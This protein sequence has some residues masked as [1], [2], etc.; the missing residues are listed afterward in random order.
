VFQYACMLIATPK[1]LLFANKQ[2]E[3]YSFNETTKN[4]KLLR[5][6]FN[7]NMES[8][9]ANST[10]L[11]FFEKGS[12]II[13]RIPLS[14][15]E[16]YFEQKTK[17]ANSQNVK[18][19]V[20]HGHTFQAHPIISNHTTMSKT[21]MPKEKKQANT[22]EIEQKGNLDLQR[23]DIFRYDTEIEVFLNLEKD[24]LNGNPN[25]TPIKLITNDNKFVI[26]D[27]QGELYSVDLELKE[28]ELQTKAARNFQCLFMLRNCHLSNT[29]LIGEGDLLLLDPIR[30]SLNKL[31]IVAGSEIIVLH[32]TKFLY[33]I[34][35]IFSA[36]GRIYFIDSSG[37]LYYFNEMDKKLTQIGNNG[38]CKYIIDF[39]VQKNY[40]LT[41]ENTNILY[42]TN[43]N[44]GNYVEIKS[45][46]CKNYEYFFAD[47]Q[48]LIFI[49]K[50][51]DI[52]VVVLNSFTPTNKENFNS[53]N[54]GKDQLKLKTTIKLPGISKQ[55]SI[56]YFKNNII[57]YNKDK[58]TIEAFNLDDRSHKKMAENF[59]EIN[60]FICNADFLACILKDGV[61]YKLYC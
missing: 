37:N 26:I 47:N 35:H 33:Q 61:I 24:H 52:N 25:I 42:K 18:L 49:T 48:Y 58:K 22:M 40:I 1:E 55:H 45:E 59:P 15:P 19:N 51:D 38:I 41:I 46:L 28:R 32:S 27:K 9:A 39:A 6:D 10:H 36:N 44:D 14:A 57:Y 16:G 29:A 20:G 53:L 50:E 3:L 23:K 31:N 11:Y 54:D 17:T 30:L 5:T 12:K 7:K 43:L 60:M 2:G 4:V 56:T 13:Y 34:K 8:Y 21:T